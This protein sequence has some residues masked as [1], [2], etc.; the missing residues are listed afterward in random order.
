MPIINIIINVRV[1]YKIFPMLQVSDL[2][3]KQSDPMKK[4]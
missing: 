3:V 4:L 1:T 2:S